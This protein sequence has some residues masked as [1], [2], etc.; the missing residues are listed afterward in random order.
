MIKGEIYY[1]DIS[2]HLSKSKLQRGTNK[3]IDIETHNYKM[4]KM[5]A[6]MYNGNV[7]LNVGHG[8]ERIKRNLPPHLQSYDVTR[9]DLIK[10]E[11]LSDTQYDIEPFI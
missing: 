5:L 7:L 1:G 9:V 4:D 11:K 6:T 3:V 10:G 2:V 8:L